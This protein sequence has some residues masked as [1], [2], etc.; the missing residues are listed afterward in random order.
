MELMILNQNLQG[1]YVMD[2]FESVIWTERYS[3]YGDFEIYTKVT[4]DMIAVLQP[5]NYIFNVES[6]YV[7]VIEDRELDFTLEDGHRFL[8][9]GRSVES[10]LDRRI[11][12]YQT[13][14]TGDLQNGIERLLNE[15]LISPTLPERA[16][17]MVSFEPS[18]DL[19]ITNLTVDAQFTRTNLYESIKKLCDANDLGFKMELSVNLDSFVFSLYKGAD[20][21]YN[22]SSNPFVVFSRN[23]DNLIS[24][25]YVENMS[26]Y[27]NVTV[28]AGE[29]E[30]DA[31]IT[32][33]VG[34]ASGVERREMYTD[35]RDI[36]KTIDG[37]T[38]S[39][40]DY[41]AQLEH[42]GME[43]LIENKME[44]TFEG[45][46][47]V[48]RM[49]KYGQDFFLGDIV[50]LVGEYGIEGRARITEMIISQNLNGSEIHPTF[51]IILE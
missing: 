25:K 38:L 40:E 7:M 9:K 3:G 10:L 24:S 46:V 48:T 45:V 43:D 14:L 23:F 26:T 34:D 12:W 50:Q 29:G 19:E 8:V 20:R 6:G 33:V 41:L 44:T 18:V 35:A 28:S 42:R 37:V 5:G 11:I 13:A 31:R 16:M 1:I 2:V 30:G 51:E 47:D 17:S 15:N 27:K 39:D 36:S 22:Q 21:S 32:K 49:L 4:D